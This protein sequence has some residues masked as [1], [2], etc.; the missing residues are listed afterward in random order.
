ML[1]TVLGW[2]G[3]LA[4]L[5][6]SPVTIGLVVLLLTLIYRYLTRHKNF[7]KGKGVA[8]KPYRFPMGNV[9]FD[10][11]KFQEGCQN[12]YDE[13]KS[14]G[15]CMAMIDWLGPAL[16]VSDPEMLKNIL[17][18]DFET[19]PVRQPT[20]FN[21]SHG[22]FSSMITNLTGQQWK[23]VR[24]I[25][26]PTFSTGK[27]RG[28]TAIL[29]ELSNTLAD[30]MFKESQ[31]DGEINVK[32]V[33]ARY[34]MDTIAS[35]AFGLE[36]DSIRNPESAI[37]KKAV[38]LRTPP[39]LFRI[40]LFMSIMYLPSFIKNRFDL[41]SMMLSNDAL[42]FFVDIAKRA[43][44]EREEHPE[45]RRND[46]LQL[47]IDSRS[48]KSQTRKLTDDEITAQ[49]LLFFF[50]GND[51]TS[52]SLTWAAREIAFHPEVQERIQA[53]IDEVL[54]SD[55]TPIDFDKVNSGMPYLESVV[56]ETLRMYPGM[57]LTRASTRDYT[58]PGTDAV[59][60]A[61]SMVYMMPYAMQR[62]A[63]LYPNPDSFDPE[64][65]LSNGKELRNSYTYLAFGQG[66]RN[67]IGMRF[68][69][70]QAKVA[71]VALLRKYS[72]VTGPK[73]GEVKPV[74]NPGFAQTQEKD[75][76]WLKIVRR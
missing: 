4:S 16:S 61:N 48:D 62:D 1:S 14:A 18:K 6:F 72:L 30:Q 3:W 63:D 25:S 60:P 24:S 31:K 74:L 37:A 23:D 45:R 76:T 35:V 21:S 9:G 40:I 13:T 51:T 75:G 43:I 64:R 20:S 57:Q 34:T 53:E 42:D 50:A 47:L 11:Y 39:S 2:L 44:K 46:Y 52:N 15:G 33:F 28:M 10:F 5:V 38:L 65:F 55:D 26:T 70:L 29:E 8:N 49:C 59:L 7:W 36:A 56:M 58:I 68:A 19:F 71:L 66:P 73:S 12:L 69:L 17:V 41:T 67:C 27:I 54:T 32:D 22:I